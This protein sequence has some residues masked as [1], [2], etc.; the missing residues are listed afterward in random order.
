MPKKPFVS[1]ITPM[2]GID[3]DAEKCISE[4]RKLDYP[5]FEIIIAPDTRQKSQIA[6][7]I[8][9]VPM[10]TRKPSA[11]RNAAAKAARGEILAFVDADAYPVKGWLKQAVR[12]FENPEIGAVGGPNVTPPEDSFSQKVSG[13]VLAS[14][15]GAGPI[16]IRHT[17]KPARF[18]DALPSVNLIVRRKLF[19]DIGG[20]DEKLTTGEDL[21]LCFDVIKKGKKIFYDPGI[22]VFHHRRHM[23]MPHLY[24]M[25][26]YGRGAA[27]VAKEKFTPAVFLK[28]IPALW[29]LF[30]VFGLAAGAIMPALMP[31]YFG[32]ILVY[33][34]VAAVSAAMQSV[35][36][37]PFSFLGIIL[38]HIFYGAGFVEGLWRKKF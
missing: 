1:I 20:Y 26:T 24:Q 9:Q 25:F 29:I 30:L 12:H 37:A 6:K 4:C 7:G 34:A 38:T 33:L 17:E 28:A 35:A 27:F 10:Q 13:D 31:F 36:R 3:K 23:W 15:V 22:K 16:S 19:M 21:Q 5:N 14:F 8:V 32:A 2:R 18:I 11:K